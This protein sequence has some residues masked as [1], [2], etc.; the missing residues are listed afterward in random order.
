LECYA[1]AQDETFETE[2]VGAGVD[3]KNVDLAQNS[4]GKCGFH[5]EN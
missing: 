1:F 5:P 2:Q 4:P 3:H